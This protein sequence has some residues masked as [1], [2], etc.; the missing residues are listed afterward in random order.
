MSLI[1]MNNDEY[2]IYHQYIKQ[3]QRYISSSHQKGLMST[4]STPD[5]IYSMAHKMMST[6]T[7]C[8]KLSLGSRGHGDTREMGGGVPKNTSQAGVDPQEQDRKTQK[9]KMKSPRLSSKLPTRQFSDLELLI[10][11]GPGNCP[12][13]VFG[14]VFDHSLDFLG[15]ASIFDD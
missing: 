14:M 10:V 9:R 11:L 5:S 7:S 12:M 1:M 8:F 2:I 15:E 3:N 13:F 4:M 6:P